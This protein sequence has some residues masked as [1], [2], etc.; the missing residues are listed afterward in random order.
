MLPAD[1]PA[2]RS[3]KTD[4]NSCNREEHSVTETKIP[5]CLH[6]SWKHRGFSRPADSSLTKKR[7]PYDCLLW[8]ARRDLKVSHETRPKVHLVGKNGDETSIRRPPA[9]G[10]WE[11]SLRFLLPGLFFCFL[12]VF[13]WGHTSLLLE[14]PRKIS[15]GL[16]AAAFCDITYAG[17]G[18][19]Q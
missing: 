3:T 10:F 14:I 13:P 16:K 19:F 5:L 12:G 15:D 9:D 18:I 1:L 8:C 2:A 7:Q 6:F 11:Q 17:I 4:V